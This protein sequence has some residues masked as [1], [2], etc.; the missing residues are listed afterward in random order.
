MEGFLPTDVSLEDR[1]LF[2]L[3]N[4]DL[5]ERIF[6]VVHPELQSQFP[7]LRVPTPAISNNLPAQPSSFVGRQSELNWLRPLVGQQRLV[8]LTG[9]GGSGKTRLALEV[10]AGVLDG[11]SEGVWLVDLAP[12]A[13]DDLVVPA[14]AEVLGITASAG[15]ALVDALVD[16]LSAQNLLLVLDNCE[17]VIGATAKVADLL[18]RHCPRVHLVATSRE[19]LAIPGETIF[20]V[21]SL[22]L[23]RPD[24]DDEHALACDSLRL[25]RDRARGHGVN[26]RLNSQMIGLMRAVC[27]R[28]DG[29]P[30]A[31]ELAAARLRSLSLS[32]LHER[33]DQRFR[34]LTSGSRT[35]LKRQQTLR[36]TVEWSY[37]LLTRSEQRVLCRLSVF[38]D[39]FEL[40]AAEAVLGQEDIE[41][42]E[43]ADLVAS[44]VDKS[45]VGVDGL[46]LTLSYRLLET[47]RDFGAELLSAD[48]AAA[49]TQAHFHYFLGLADQAAPLLDS[50]GQREWLDRLD[51]VRADLRKALAHACS[52]PNRTADALRLCSALRTYWRWRPWEQDEMR[53]LLEV[54]RRPDA[55]DYLQLKGTGLLSVGSVMK[56]FDLGL[57]AALIEEAA[58]IFQ[59]TEDARSLATA[60][61]YLCGYYYSKG[62]LERAFELASETAALARAVG[63]DTAL[64]RAI[65]YLL[66]CS[67][68]LD[69]ETE[70]RLLEEGL[71]CT[72]RSG[73][74]A[75]RLSIHNSAGDIALRRGDLAS[76]RMHLEQASRLRG[77]I[78]GVVNWPITSN[79]GFLQRLEG[80]QEHAYEG[81][82]EVLRY[83]H[84]HHDQFGITV[85]L[86]GLACV[87]VDLG[88]SAHGALL[89]GAVDRVLAAFG[90]PFEG[91]ELRF[92]GESE[93][94]ARLQLG[95]EEYE[96]HYHRGQTS[97]LNQVVEI[98]LGQ[99]E[100]D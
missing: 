26:L 66:L 38:P 45:L 3:N 29:M 58:G 12:L 7:V 20:R 99:P 11:W 91:I 1:G 41:L 83:C 53:A 65:K 60:N 39:T 97:D 30:L 25:F 98:A 24:D 16:A 81:F 46:A 50:S 89:H 22:S 85:G 71:A 93:S 70:R 40:K 28:L 14:L 59:T 92:R 44:L 49:L 84:R 47:I 17:H 72:S 19:P 73:D 79:L 10:A 57:G 13:D 27:A 35:A 96:R 8:T 51:S 37:S 67:S 64:A 88:D 54:L 4:F 31:I 36:A 18:L 42:F 2:L 23:P 63:D 61:F 62:D 77:E 34:I 55:G 6:Q 68:H 5:P 74:L 52:V 43:V 82:T 94:A 78:G 32:D 48:E 90:V 21:P 9:A 75:G 69:P 95:D 76:A 33:L 86:L 87:A 15:T 56:R 80:E 100:R